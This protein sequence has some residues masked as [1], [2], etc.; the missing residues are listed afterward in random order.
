MSKKDRAQIDV[1]VSEIVNVIA[2]AKAI[3]PYEIGNETVLTRAIAS[4]LIKTDPL[5]KGV[6]AIMLDITLGKHLDQ[7]KSTQRLPGK[8]PAFRKISRNGKKGT[9]YMGQASAR[10]W[11]EAGGQ[12]KQAEDANKN[13]RSTAHTVAKTMRA[14]KIAAFDHNPQAI[15]AQL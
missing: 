4:N 11:D 6:N 14:Q 12:Y 3:P 9:I 10:E 15:L 5:F 13:A 8:L 2:T 1:I 7:A